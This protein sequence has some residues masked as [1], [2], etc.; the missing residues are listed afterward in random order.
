LTGHDQ[1]NR[2]PFAADLYYQ[3]SSRAVASTRPPVALIH[4]AGGTHLYWPS[5][6]RRLTGERVYALDLPGHG[7]SG[8]GVAERS[9]ITAG[10]AAL[11]N[12][13]DALKLETAALIGHSMG[14]AIALTLALDAPER[15]ARLGL[16]GG[17]PRLK[18]HPD[19]LALTAAPETYPQAAQLITEWSYAET[20]PAAFKQRSLTRLL[21][22]SS[23]VLHADLL[24][25]NAFDIRSRLS[26]IHCPTLILTGEADR[27]TPPKF[28]RALAEAIP[29]SRLHL[30][31]QAGHML[32]LERP[33]ETA[34][35]LSKFLG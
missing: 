27:M 9:S 22:V 2:M 16:L 15:V 6:V 12:W 23:E 14:S 3:L 7:K 31:P 4:G 20:V 28:A 8:Q 17:G 26:E 25:C 32:M 21:E 11:L 19:L 5:E 29:N 34:A 13:M 33:Q 30:I 1:E 10:A 35:I 18:V 24:A